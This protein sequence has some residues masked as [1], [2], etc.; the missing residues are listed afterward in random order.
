MT[1]RWPRRLR[2]G[3]FVK[4]ASFSLAR[5]PPGLPAF[6]DRAALVLCAAGH[7]LRSR[8]P[9]PAE[10]VVR[11]GQGVLQ[12]VPGAFGVVPTRSA[13]ATI[14]CMR[15]GIGVSPGVVIGKAYCIHE[16]FVNPKTRRLAEDKIFA[17]LRRF[18]LAPRD[19]RRGPARPASESRQPGR[20]RASGGVSRPRGNPARPG[21]HGQ[22][23]RAN[24][25]PSRGRPRGARHV[26]A[27]YTGFSRAWK[28][29]TCVNGWST[30][31][32]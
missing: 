8:K 23:A 31:A 27:G 5:I 14:S 28:T 25:R 19:S 2:M 21:L 32:M 18:E 9:S 12:V 10:P 6:R 17:E 29:S 7:G 26:L 4:F 13:I 15:K 11:R 1:S 22:G 30:F 3:L 24:R 20:R 16:I